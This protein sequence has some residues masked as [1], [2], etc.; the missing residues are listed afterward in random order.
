M[1]WPVQAGGAGNLQKPQQRNWR[2]TLDRV[3]RQPP[4]GH[5]LGP[6]RRSGVQRALWRSKQARSQEAGCGAACA[7]G[8]AGASCAPPETALP[9]RTSAAPSVAKLGWL[10]S[11]P[12]PLCCCCCCAYACVSECVCLRVDVCGCECSV[13]ALAALP[14]ATVAAGVLYR[15]LQMRPVTQRAT[16]M[17]PHAPDE[18]AGPCR[19]PP[20]DLRASPSDRDRPL[21]RSTAAMASWSASRHRSAGRAA[22]AASIDVADATQP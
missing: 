14:R 8:G 18:A 12:P 1:P 9:Q 13:R 5:W 21:S 17:D 4:R 19:R 3:K 22:A 16:P 7:G 15:F 11:P 10:C 6:A 2:G 20:Q